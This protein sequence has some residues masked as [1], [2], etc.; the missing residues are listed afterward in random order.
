MTDALAVSP[1]LNTATFQEIQS[2]SQAEQRQALLDLFC[3]LAYQTGEFTL[4]SGQRSSYYVNSKRVTLH[5]Q[6]ALVIGQLFL[7]QLPPQTEAV[8]GLTLGADPLVSAISV[9]SAYQ[10][11]PIPAL[12]VR[13]E[14]KGHGTQAYLEGPLLK[15][16]SQVVVIEDVVTTGA[17]A[18]QAVDRLRL[19]GYRVHHIMALVD[20]QQGGADLYAGQGLTFQSLFTIA[21]IQARI[22]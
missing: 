15:P 1:R 13:K 11:C 10:N 5:P 12:I 19:A 4:S 9:V 20:R 3:E 2:W 8:G 16:G 17:S 7:A 18:L 22:G 21:E 6:G 14:P